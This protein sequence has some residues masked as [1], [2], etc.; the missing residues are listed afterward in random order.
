MWA[1]ADLWG[2]AGEPQGTFSNVGGASDK[3][4]R[5]WIT[6]SVSW[7]DRCANHRMTGPAQQDAMTANTP[8]APV[9]GVRHA[10]IIE[11]IGN[12]QLGMTDARAPA[13]R[14]PHR[15]SPRLASDRGLLPAVPAQRAGRPP[16]AATRPTTLC[17]AFRCRAR[18]AL[19]ALRGEGPRPLSPSGR[20]RATDWR[21]PCDA[22]RPTP[23]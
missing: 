9:S 15:G 13:R 23:T 2:K 18:A 5:N 6:K 10:L 12:I 21:S 20:G 7:H 16:V 17:P 8:G 4:L 11:Q 14:L 22:P 1:A 19:P 3:M